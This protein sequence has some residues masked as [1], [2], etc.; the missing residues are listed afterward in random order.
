M[1]LLKFCCH[2]GIDALYRFAFA[3]SIAIVNPRVAGQ[4]GCY[5]GFRWPRVCPTELVFRDEGDMRDNL[6]SA[7]ESRFGCPD[8]VIVDDPRTCRLAQLLQPTKL[9]W[10]N[11]GT[12][13]KDKAAQDFFK[14]LIPGVDAVFNSEYKKKVVSTW[15]NLGTSYVVPIAL[16]PQDFKNHAYTF[17]SRAVLY[18]NGLMQK[19]SI[20]QDRAELTRQIFEALT[21]RHC[22]RIDVYG[23]DNH[24][25]GEMNKGYIFNPSSLK[26][27]S[28]A[29]FPLPNPQPSFA[30]LEL[31]AMGI[32]AIMLPPKE[33]FDEANNYRSY[34][35]AESPEAF[36]SGLEHLVNSPGAAAEMGARGRSYVRAHF[37]ATRWA[38]S[39]RKIV[40]ECVSK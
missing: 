37:S 24:F 34:I 22:K 31:M 28:A 6:K 29:L 39:L 26:A 4:N 21:E 11:H 16:L 17:N 38:A 35:L 20:Y 8:L 18:G 14:T 2:G 15:M 10:H 9:L 32:P 13:I 27:Y 7:L 23:S 1:R 36:A 33:G 40:E 12:Y 5:L 19:L 25:F 30:Q 3:S